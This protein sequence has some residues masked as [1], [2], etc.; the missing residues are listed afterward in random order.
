VF[1]LKNEAVSLVRN[2]GIPY[3]IFYPSTFMENF[4]STYRA[5]NR[6]LLAGKSEHKM[7]FISGEDYGRQVARSFQVLKTENKEYVVQGL[8]GFTA[9]E[10]AE[11]FRKHH[12]SEKLTISKAP[13]GL[14][15]LLGTFSQKINYGAHIIEALNK[16]P[17][18]FESEK[19]WEELGKPVV[20]LKAFA[21]KY[22]RIF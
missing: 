13:L 22:E 17:E 18:K 8:E 4:M 10:A 1:D 15:K 9:D 14:L 12:T 2:S 5:G 19:T 20:T 6:V 21:K 11:E 7:Y 16:Y 3:T